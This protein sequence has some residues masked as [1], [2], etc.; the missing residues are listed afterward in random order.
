MLHVGYKNSTNCEQGSVT[1][2]IERIASSLS[3]GSGEDMRMMF[4]MRRME[5]E[6][7]EERR[8]QEREE[9]RREREEMRQERIEMEDRRERRFERQMQQ[10]SEMMQM[11]MMVM[12]G[13]GRGSDKKS[14]DSDNNVNM[15]NNLVVKPLLICL[16]MQIMQYKKCNKHSPLLIIF[17]SIS[18]NIIILEFN[19]LFL[20]N[21][22]FIPIS[23]GLKV[24]WL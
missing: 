20:L 23:V 15:G 4:E 2:L 6:E 19:I 5:W 16:L 12:M 18:N 14:G 22:V 3:S 7:A 1:K 24:L 17:E 13:R 8:R 21:I 11:M 10:Q 9:A